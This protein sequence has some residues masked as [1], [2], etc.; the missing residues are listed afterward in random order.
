MPAT[1]RVYVLQNRSSKFYIGV[2]DDVARRI[3]QHN[4]GVSRWTRGKGAWKLVWESERMSFS[5]ARK[6]ELL[7][8]RQKRGDG[9]Y[10][11][12]GLPRTGA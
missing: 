1:Y 8:K 12:T 11:L 7:L 4:V 10:R 5:E 9:F 3:E 6:L 2:S